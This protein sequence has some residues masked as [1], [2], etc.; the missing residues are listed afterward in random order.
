M[1]LH[2]ARAHPHDKTQLMRA[3]RAFW[4]GVPQR[5]IGNLVLSFADR[6]ERCKDR[7]GAC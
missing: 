3:M 5:T 4:E 1:K 2:V 6:L 7:D